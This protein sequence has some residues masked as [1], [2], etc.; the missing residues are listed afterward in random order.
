MATRSQVVVFDD[1]I[2]LWDV[3]TGKE[4]KKI[5]GHTDRVYS[6]AFSIDGNTLASGSW[7]NTV[8]LWDVNTGRENQ[9]THWAYTLRPVAY[10]SVL[11]GTHSQVA[12]LTIPSV[13]GCQHGQR[14]EKK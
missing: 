6:V 3:N 10:H 8:R 13:C 4:L 14:T 12:V 1:T 5:T 7:D 2:R 9:K 11:I